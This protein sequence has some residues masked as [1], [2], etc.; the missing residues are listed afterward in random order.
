MDAG[1]PVPPRAVQGGE[2]HRHDVPEVRGRLVQGAG[3]GAPL[4]ADSSLRF[5]GFYLFEGGRSGV[6]AAGYG[7]QLG[8]RSCFSPA[9]YAI[10]Y[11]K[12][13]H[14]VT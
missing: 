8:S 11:A 12:E 7:G 4:A 1:Q 9:R 6:V 10:P 5:L 2:R 3:V 13:G 14:P